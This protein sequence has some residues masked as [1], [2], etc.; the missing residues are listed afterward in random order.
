MIVDP[1]AASFIACI[2]RHG[3][4]FV[5]PTKNSVADGI[6]LVGSLLKQ[7][8]LRFSRRCEGLIREFSLYRW[9]GR[10][11]RDCPVKEHDHAMDDMRYFAATVL[12]EPEG[13]AFFAACSRGGG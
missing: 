2:R 3:R 6:R 1:S 8:K 13:G 9:D 4:F 11:G 10:A 5:I 7:G 12:D